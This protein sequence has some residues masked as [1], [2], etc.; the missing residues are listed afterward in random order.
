MSIQASRYYWENVPELSG[1]DL[2][3]IQV[4][5]DCANDA[6][7]AWP[8]VAYIAQ[9][10]RLSDRGVQKSCIRLVCR[11]YLII[12]KYA[13]IKTGSG[14]ATHRYNLLH[15]QMAMQTATWTAA[16]NGDLTAA[17]ANFDASKGEP[18][19]PPFIV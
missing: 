13:G 2:I 5:A 12:Q 7:V 1:N 4:L 15:Y 18:M 11:G 8:S 9:R 10:S 14:S 6:G 16:T 3:I 19:R 17:R